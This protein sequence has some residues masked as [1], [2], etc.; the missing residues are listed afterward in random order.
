MAGA[1]RGFS[2]VVAFLFFSDSSAHLRRRDIQLP[3]YL[4]GQK[5]LYFPMSRNS[6]KVPVPW[7]QKN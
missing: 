6:S 1:A 4:P 5:G 3:T 2:W 7:V